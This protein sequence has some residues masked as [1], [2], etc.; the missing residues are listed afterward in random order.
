MNLKKMLY[1][2]SAT[3]AL[4]APLALSGVIANADTIVP[5]KT[6][7]TARKDN[8]RASKI[9]TPSFKDNGQAQRTDAPKL[10]N[11]PFYQKGFLKGSFFDNFVKAPRL[12]GSNYNVDNKAYSTSVTAT[13]NNSTLNY[14]VQTYN[15]D[16]TPS[17]KAFAIGIS[18][19][20]SPYKVIKS[21]TGSLKG[22]LTVNKGT[23]T[24]Q[25]LTPQASSHFTGGL[26]L[27]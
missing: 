12:G 24:L 26:S 10:T 21:T 16:G 20:G 1:A 23:Y 22:S 8:G 4:V 14:N 19:N 7:Q 18:K 17:N 5:I 2:S 6:T 25:V 13:H 3:L 9:D 11:N 27:N 15:S